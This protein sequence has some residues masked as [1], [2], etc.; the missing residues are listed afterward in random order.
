MPWEGGGVGGVVRGSKLLE[1]GCPSLGPHEILEV[2]LGLGGLGPQ[3]EEGVV[4]GLRE[5]AELPY[6]S[7]KLGGARTGWGSAVPKELASCLG[8]AAVCHLGFSPSVVL[9]SSLAGGGDFLGEAAVV[10][11]GLPDPD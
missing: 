11:L 10:G 9:A 5:C 1:M 3:F 2:C 7:C 6:K 4:M 8:E